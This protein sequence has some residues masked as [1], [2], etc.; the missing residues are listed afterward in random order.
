ML[1]TPIPP[2]APN[3]AVAATALPRRLGGREAGPQPVQRAWACRSSGMPAR[4]NPCCL[5][6]TFHSYTDGQITVR[7]S[8]QPPRH[9]QT[10][11]VTWAFGW[12]QLGSNQ[13]PLACKACHHHSPDLPLVPSAQVRIEQPRARPSTTEQRRAKCAPNCAPTS[14]SPC[15]WQMLGL[16]S[17]V[18]TPVSHAGSQ[19]AN[20]N[21]D[22]T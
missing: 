1:R 2:I 16:G 12:A 4:D 11:I 13:R 7:R 8:S 10:S 6:A 20:K 5:V 19:T 22:A 3:A 21:S 9:R 15:R 18:T 14:S 17:A